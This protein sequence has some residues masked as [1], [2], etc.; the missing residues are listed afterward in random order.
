MLDFPSLPLG[1]LIDERCNVFELFSV[2]PRGIPKRRYL[3]IANHH[4]GGYV[5][6]VHIYLITRGVHAHPKLTQIPPFKPRPSQTKSPS[7][8]INM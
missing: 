4:S 6:Q 1:G 3:S 5:E 7:K 8:F 2:E